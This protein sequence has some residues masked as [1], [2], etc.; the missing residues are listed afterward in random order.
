MNRQ[1]RRTVLVLSVVSVY[2]ANSLK[3][4][5]AMKAVDP[6]I[7]VCIQLTTPGAWPDGVTNAAN[8]K[9]WNETVLSAIGAKTDCVIIH[10]Y[11]AG[12]PPSTDVAAALEYPG[13]IAGMVSAA[14]AQVKQYIGLNQ[15]SVQI[16]V[17]E[18]NSNVAVDVQPSALF[19][20]DSYLTWF[21][22][23][24]VASYKVYQ[25]TP[26]GRTL[27]ASPA[28]TTLDLGGLTIGATYRYQAVAVDSHGY[29]SLPTS[30]ATVTVPP[31]AD[32]SCAAHHEISNSWQ[33][34]FIAAITLTNRAAT[35]VS[36][37]RVTF[38]WP[39][40][41]Q[42]VTN[43]WGATWTQSGRQVTVTAAGTIAGGG[44]TAS[45]G[46]QGGYTAQN[47]APTVFYL[48]GVPCSNV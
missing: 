1:A 18:T 28:A 43:G 34:G 4:I 37:G 14:K 36:D 7:R 9:S 15:A 12:F 47:P 41:G 8:P 35:P 21:E 6:N 48:N 40:D 33:G 24:P 32:A 26:A 29:E 46:F 11:P 22:N 19:A 44:G 23:H 5:A 45:L 2:A 31:P 39:A 10:W 27:V 16:M 17:T 13:Q 30:P 25:L 38:S 42:S 20:A 3:F